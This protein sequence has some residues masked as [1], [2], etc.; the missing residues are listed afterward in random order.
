MKLFLITFRFWFCVA[1]L[2]LLSRH[3]ALFGEYILAD[4]EH[5]VPLLLDASKHTNRDVKNRGAVALESVLWQA[6]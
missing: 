5:L 1:A 6:S 3:A 2:T 4:S